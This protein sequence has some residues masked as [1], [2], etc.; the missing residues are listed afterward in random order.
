MSP[1]LS[2]IIPV[3]NVESYLA[4]CL[5]SALSQSFHEI[6]IICINDGSTDRSLQILREYEKK[7]PRV[8]V[9]DKANA[10][11]GAAMNDG[12]DAATGEYVG[13][14][15]SDDY[16]CE[17]AWEKLYTLAKEHDLDIVKG[18][19]LQFTDTKESYFD[20]I[21]K[22][23]RH[24]PDQLPLVPIGTVFKPQ[25]YPRCF[26]I[27][28]SIWTAIYKRDFLINNNIRFN[29]TPGASYQDTSFAFKVWVASKRAMAVSFPVIHY[30]LDSAFSSSNSRAKVFAVC[31]E[32]EEC[33]AYLDS[34][35]AEKDLY[36]ILCAVRYKTYLWNIDRVSAAFKLA[37]LERMSKEFQ[38]DIDEGNL[39]SKY[40]P[41]SFHEEFLAIAG[42]D[43]VP[44]NDEIT[45]FKIVR[46][47]NPKPNGSDADFTVLIPFSNHEQYL[48][49]CLASLSEQT[50]QHFEV[51]LIDT[52]SEDNSLNLAQDYVAQHPFSTLASAPNSTLYNAL[53]FSLEH[54]K[55]CYIQVVMPYDFL[56]PRALEIEAQYIGRHQLDTLALGIRATYDSSFVEERFKKQGNPYAAH[57]PYPSATQGS[58][59]LAE[60]ENAG[61]LHVDPWSF[62][63]SRALMQKA[64]HRELEFSELGSDLMTINALLSAERAGHTLEAVYVRRFTGRPVASR[65]KMTRAILGRLENIAELQEIIDKYSQS[66]FI[67]RSLSRIASEWARICRVDYRNASSAQRFE[68]SHSCN[69]KVLELLEHI[70][71][72]IKADELRISYERRGNRLQRELNEALKGGRA[73]KAAKKLSGKLREVRNSL[74]VR[75]QSKTTRQKIPLTKANPKILMVLDSSNNDERTRSTVELARVLNQLGE[76]VHVAL[77]GKGSIELVLNTERVP[78][79]VFEAY[80]LEG[81]SKHLTDVMRHEP[82]YSLTSKVVAKLAQY[83]EDEHFD[84]VHCINDNALYG[85]LAAKQTN[86]P[87]IFQAQSAKGATLP[88]DG[89]KKEEALS[90]AEAYCF[91]S[92]IYKQ[93]FEK[94]HPTK[95]AHIIYDG[96]E[97]HLF[98]T[99]RSSTKYDKPRI[100]LYLEALTAKNVEV[101]ATALSA[102]STLDSPIYC[103]VISDVAHH[104]AISSLQSIIANMGLEH[105]VTLFGARDDMPAVWHHTDIAML[106]SEDDASTYNGVCAMM[107]G[108]P[109]VCTPMHACCEIVEN[110][111]TG[112]IMEGATEK[113]F[114]ATIRGLL[115]NPHKTR[116]VASAGQQV[117]RF[118]YTLKE[119]AQALYQIH[120]E[121]FSNR[122]S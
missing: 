103:S 46:Q 36:R 48:K 25:D 112:F 110:N 107:A 97:P 89:L 8:K 88:P 32:M 93:I 21:A 72:G 23:A 119:N 58:F 84:I 26:W 15:E 75:G 114:E 105:S 122:I 44:T 76:E 81:S 116:K 11:Y 64:L 69:E 12:L 63:A 106:V 5:D 50:H 10:G 95:P 42:R 53:R 74:N 65:P 111:K 38:V 28:P 117:A 109:L 45:S 18:C 80:K 49:Q 70:C 55:G 4:E 17:H 82:T 52:G 92:A 31:D 33:K 41:G 54:A 47:N 96:A 19:Y 22:V 98:F 90:C 66:Y 7:D 35:D 39:S 83:I 27:N 14:L 16:A 100:T 99:P 13:I 68:V 40:I 3:C 86:T 104:D 113:D 62:V 30:R 2:V 43:D 85:A 61:D 71:W 102:I 101:L 94:H 73:V 67:E 24:C 29:E 120:K 51:F 91:S 56:E 60:M 121:L 57:R 78:Y 115:E 118:C 20:A 79:R 37:F 1:K 34:I 87:C 9:I 108:V 77:P 6:E 59:L